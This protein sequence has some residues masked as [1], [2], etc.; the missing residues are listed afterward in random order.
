LPL[1]VLVGLGAGDTCGL[2]R[3]RE[4]IVAEVNGGHGPNDAA[5]M[6]ARPFSGGGP[7]PLDVGVKRPCA[8]RVASRPSK[9]PRKSFGTAWIFG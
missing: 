3:V 5:Q 4:F 7:L 8:A 2:R 9:A 6:R 1:R